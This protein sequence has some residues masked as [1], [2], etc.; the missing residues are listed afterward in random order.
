MIGNCSRACKK[1]ASKKD[2]IGAQLTRAEVE[3]VVY[4]QDLH[5]KENYGNFRNH[6]AKNNVI[7]RSGDIAISMA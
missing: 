3:A 2:Y 4:T 6:G 5:P 7:M 1:A